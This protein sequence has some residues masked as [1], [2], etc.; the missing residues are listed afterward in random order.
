V[1]GRLATFS[2]VDLAM[3]VRKID[4]AAGRAPRKPTRVSSNGNDGHDDA[5]AGNPSAGAVRLDEV[6]VVVAGPRRSS[7]QRRMKGLESME[8]ISESQTESREPAVATAASIVWLPSLKKAA[9][10]IF[11]SRE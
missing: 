5:S 10:R 11:T 3:F 9:K 2:I 7:N 6:E 4:H 1:E 8:P